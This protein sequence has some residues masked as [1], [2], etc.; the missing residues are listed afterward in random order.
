MPQTVVRGR[1]SWTESA[2]WMQALFRSRWEFETEIK[3]SRE[4]VVSGGGSIDSSA[5]KRL[6]EAGLRWRAATWRETAEF[7][8]LS[9][10]TTRLGAG[11][12]PDQARPS[13]VR[14]GIAQPSSR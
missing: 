10:R 2:R 1:Y 3:V 8:L 14:P 7:S 6:Q 9:S 13:A 5:W 4:P 12:V 11:R